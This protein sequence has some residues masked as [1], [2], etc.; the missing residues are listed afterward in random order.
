MKTKRYEGKTPDEIRELLQSGE[1]SRSTHYRIR[2]E[3]G[4]NTKPMH[5]NEEYKFSKGPW[6]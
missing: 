5:A 1:M 3:T 2:K 4:I 6:V